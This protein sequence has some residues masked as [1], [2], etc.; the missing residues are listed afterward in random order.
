MNLIKFDSIIGLRLNY[1]EE[2]GMQIGRKS[3]HEYDVEKKTQKQDK[4][5]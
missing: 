3:A 5:K 2:I 4:S 1:I